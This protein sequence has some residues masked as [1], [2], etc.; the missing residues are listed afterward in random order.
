MCKIIS[1]NVLPLSAFDAVTLNLLG[2]YPNSA[3]YCKY[4]EAVQKIPLIRRCVRTDFISSMLLL[5]GLEEQQR[6]VALVPIV[7][8]RKKSSKYLYPKFVM[9]AD[10][11]QS[12]IGHC[13]SL[14][15]SQLQKRSSRRAICDTTII[16]DK[17]TRISLFRVC[18]CHF[19]E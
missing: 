11:S 17:S 15:L 16:P 12:S 14:C 8:L 10:V 3:V 7:S 6:V 18:L 19:L 13:F 9:N 2:C 5:G 1:G 4:T